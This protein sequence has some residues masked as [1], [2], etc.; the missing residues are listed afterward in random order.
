MKV[1]LRGS[2]KSKCIDIWTFLTI[3]LLQS[4]ALAA[5]EDIHVRIVHSWSKSFYVVDKKNAITQVKTESKMK[6]NSIKRTKYRIWVNSIKMSWLD[7]R[8]CTYIQYSHEC[9]LIVFSSHIFWGVA[10]RSFLKNRFFME[11][12]IITLQYSQY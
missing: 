5:V 11:I 2:L 7:Q 12:E 8:R 6:K 4:P 1:V 3:L 9:S 10:L